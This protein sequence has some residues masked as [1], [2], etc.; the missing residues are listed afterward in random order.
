MI[1]EKIIYQ[2]LNTCIE[3]ANEKNVEVS[4]NEEI[5]VVKKIWNIIINEILN[6]LKN[7]SYTEEFF[8]NS[9]LTNVEIDTAL[10]NKF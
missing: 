10:K 5:I 7:I 6:S 2:W 1:P 8:N 3:I 9:L 4:N